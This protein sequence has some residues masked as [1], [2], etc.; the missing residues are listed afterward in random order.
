MFSEVRYGG[1]NRLG[2]KCLWSREST[3]SRMRAELEGRPD[4]NN[5]AVFHLDSL[6]TVHNNG[7]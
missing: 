4:L 3:A 2:L 7:I 1:R 6:R 5:N